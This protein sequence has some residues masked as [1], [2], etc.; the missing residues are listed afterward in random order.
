MEPKF[1]SS[2][3]PKGPIATPG[4][5]SAPKT[6][7]LFGT[8]AVFIFAVSVVMAIGVFG[9]ERF[10]ISR[11]GTMGEGLVEA[12]STIDTET[13]RELMRMDARILST[14]GLLDKHTAITPL[15]EFLEANTLQNVRF[16]DFSY[17]TTDKGLT[18][19][20]KGQARGYSAVA[21]QS[22][23]FNRSKFIKSPAFSDLDLDLKGNVTFSFSATLDPV[24]IS[25]KTQLQGVVP[26]TPSVTPQV[27][28]TTTSTTT[29]PTGT[30][31]TTPR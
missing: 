22:E 5:F 3:I 24:F 12:R 26:V 8:I 28:G 15:F 18:L 6:R 9:Y 1:Q 21:L 20:M 13:I 23:M 25:Y 19:A 27:V 4:K 2:F 10:L 14:A 31:T 11:I 30:A 17:S 16:T 7:S 29:R